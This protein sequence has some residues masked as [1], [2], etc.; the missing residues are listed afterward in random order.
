MRQIKAGDWNV[1]EMAK[2]IE[3]DLP[4]SRRYRT[5]AQKSQKPHADYGT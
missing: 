1:A 3:G 5:S 2:A 4:C